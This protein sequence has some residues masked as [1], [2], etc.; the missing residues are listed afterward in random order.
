MKFRK[1]A[2][3][4]RKPHVSRKLLVSTIAM[5]LAAP[6]I[7]HAQSFVPAGPGT[8]VGPSAVMNGADLPQPGQPTNV[9]PY[10]ATQSGAIQ[11]LAFDPANSNTLLAAS[12][13][14]G[15]FKSTDGGQTW[16]P[17]TDQQASLS[18]A[19]LSFDSTDPTGNTVIGG[20]GL[21]SSGAT[22]GLNPYFQRSRG[23]AAYG[24]ILSNDA[25]STWTRIASGPA[26]G[27]PELNFQGVSARGNTIMAA[28]FNEE[29]GWAYGNVENGSGLY[30]ST[31]GGKTFSL[32]SGAAGS[33]LPTGAA[34]ALVADPS[35][36]NRFY[37]SIT[38]GAGDMAS[39]AVYTTSNG[40]QTWSK[41]FGMS[42]A[43]GEIGSDPTMLRLA[44][45]PGG[46]VALAVVDGANGSIVGA[47]L[48]QDNGSSWHDLSKAVQTSTPTGGGPE[49][50]GG[51]DHLP[52]R[53]V[54]TYHPAPGVAAPPQTLNPGG[55][56]TIHSVI[57]IDPNNPNIVYLA[58]DRQA[59]I[60]GDTGSTSYSANAI[61]IAMN[62]DGSY[63]YAPITDNYTAD[64]STVHPDSRAFAFDAQGNLLMGTDG[65]V[66]TR[67]Q[68][69]GSNGVWRG[70][71]WGRQALEVYSMALDPH[72]GLL[73]VA[74][75]DN[76]VA[77]QS[78]DNRS[79]Y[80]QVM[81]GDG[82]VAAINGTSDP[83]HSYTYVSCQYMCSYAPQRI[84]T[85]TQGNVTQ[86]YVTD[87]YLSTDGGNS[88]VEMDSNT[89]LFVPKLKLNNIDASYMAM[90]GADSHGLGL[91][92]AQDNF[93]AAPYSYSNYSQITQA[94][95][96]QGECYEILPAAFAG[97]TGYNTSID[98]GTR[99]NTF[100]LLAGSS[101]FGG[102]HLF[103]STGS[104]PSSLN[105]QPVSSY[106]GYAP[107]SVLFDPRTQNRFFATDTQE[108]Y[109]TRDGGGTG[110]DIAANLP[111]NFVRPQTL[112]F[113]S[114]NGVNEL[115]VGGLNDVS[116]AGSPLVIADSNANGVLSDWRRFGT[117]LPNALIT[118][119]DYVPNLDALAVGTF[120]R[121][122]F[123]LYDFTSNFSSAKVLQFGLANNDSNPDIALLSGA[124]PLIKYGT[125]I[126]TINGD[127]TYT[128]GSTLRAGTLVLNGSLLGNI[129]VDGGSVFA[130]NGT[131]GSLSNQGGGTLMFSYD[132]ASQNHSMLNVDNTADISGM[133]LSLVPA[134][135]AKLAFYRQ[136]TLVQASNLSGT[137]ANTT[138]GWTPLSNYQAPAPA[139]A[140]ATTATP[141]SN[142]QARIDYLDNSVLLQ[143]LNPIDWTA[144]T[145][146]SNQVAIGTALNGVETQALNTPPS[147]SMNTFL[148]ALNPAATGNIPL[149]IEA[150]SGESSVA[151]AQAINLTGQR[152]VD[153]VNG[154]MLGAP[155]CADEATQQ[156][157]CKGLGD[158]PGDH[159]LWV[160][161]TYLNTRL[162]G[163]FQPNRFNGQG[164]AIGMDIG[165][166][167]RAK[168][169]VA[170][171]YGD[172]TTRTPAL[173]TTKVKAHYGMLAAYTK[174][175]FGRWY[176]G[177][178]LSH[179]QGSSQADRSI[180]QNGGGVMAF[181]GSPHGTSNL[182]Q[183]TGGFDAHFAKRWFVQPYVNATLLQSSRD[184]Y[185]ETGSG[186]ALGLTYGRIKQHRFQGDLGVRL[187]LQAGSQA[188]RFQPYLG[189]VESFT[190]GDRQAVSQV[191]FTQMP[192]A[193]FE[194][195][196]NLLPSSWLSAELGM[197]VA[198]TRKLVFDLSYRG[199]LGSSLHDQRV[200]AGLAFRF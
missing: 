148:T 173:S 121:G 186:S 138:A 61:R 154:Q 162:D 181:S 21:T 96:C 125:G 50:N 164:I 90:A 56:A 177:A 35:N 82:T 167:A 70:L 136:Y 187:G 163:Q 190:S 59:S 94:S 87:V 17:T 85:D 104:S 100:A 169:G 28:A 67:S 140:S 25:G 45:G 122:A 158:A 27:L 42:N 117:G 53:P 20:I 41:V 130:P 126:L 44:T 2:R 38:N 135:T 98:F 178:I 103:L 62:A 8:E 160:E 81:G 159:R 196:S 189:L 142:D 84:Q 150:L 86:N 75:Q 129:Q 109:Y 113:V 57:A 11:A 101:N 72:S 128:G 79:I 192:S 168:A 24:L 22:Y 102:S 49:A 144:G 77:M 15:V 172:V 74:A 146:N 78:P 141:A 182:L 194:V 39:T 13:N 66:Y 26:T 118:S 119:L 151:S 123:M 199:T 110:T 184:G 31:D 156:A 52:P 175:R 73:T 198:V 64:H 14:G 200:N 76:G 69:Q 7:A 153:A 34:S 47:Y 3:A 43:N 152:F 16:T 176:A 183:L 132:L 60:P 165:L 37:V 80:N 83:N 115:L 133:D 157:G 65:G 93:N 180:V 63:N 40:G 29:G 197:H 55:Q 114:S 23:G 185:T 32:V 137:F 179:S 10:Y 48:S 1:T 143:M 107:T 51:G 97:N 92:V 12:P 108:L 91:F 171:G 193:S 95:Q 145:S 127:A 120:G 124:R 116:N 134:S 139:T 155:G 195:R 191:S 99:D 89:L 161:G 33:G 46:S 5:A 188:H 111:S 170:L 174:Y 68:P 112:G 58:G 4:G 149:N 54:A 147:S 36:P 19:S 6:M 9:A 18:M 88:I 105:L 131:V 71:N 166:G 106:T 30:R